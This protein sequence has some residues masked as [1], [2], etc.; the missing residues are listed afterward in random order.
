MKSIE[1]FLALGLATAIGTSANAVDT[2]YSSAAVEANETQ[3]L[4]LAEGGEGGEGG[5][6]AVTDEG[7]ES[8]EAVTDEGGE[9]GEGGEAVTDEG[10]EGS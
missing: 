3:A 5:E 6:A 9:G 8:G 10:G 1:L 4:I 2:G 7:G